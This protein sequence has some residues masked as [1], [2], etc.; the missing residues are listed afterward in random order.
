MLQFT[1]IYQ[2]S[3]SI[4]SSYRVFTLK[5]NP[6]NYLVKRTR[7]DFKWLCDKLKEEFPSVSIPP[8][9][10]GELSKKIIEDFF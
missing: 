4:F 8:L 6:G 1:S 9:D 3:K 5:T 2:E 7:L 10:K